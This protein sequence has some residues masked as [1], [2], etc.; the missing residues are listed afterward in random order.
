MRA[1]DSVNSQPKVRLPNAKL[2]YRAEKSNFPVW[3]FGRNLGNYAVVSQFFIFAG[4]S[5]FLYDGKGRVRTSDLADRGLLTYAR[6]P[7]SGANRLQVLPFLA[8]MS[9]ISYLCSRRKRDM[10]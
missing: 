2:I 3:C 5:F 1:S 6:L 8:I 9:L 4:S 10:G 7:E